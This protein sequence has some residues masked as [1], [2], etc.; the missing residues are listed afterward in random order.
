MTY[1]VEFRTEDYDSVC[2]ALTDYENEPDVANEQ[3]VY[4]A[5]VRVANAMARAMN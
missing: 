2:R 5:L 4:N 3:A 1:T